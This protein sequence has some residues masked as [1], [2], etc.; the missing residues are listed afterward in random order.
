[1]RRLAGRFKDGRS[2][3]EDSFCLRNASNWASV[4]GEHRVQ[5]TSQQRPGRNPCTACWEVGV[6]TAALQPADFC[7][8]LIVDSKGRRDQVRAK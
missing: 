2:D 4:R 5:S 3:G 1:M 7:P 8:C 6:V